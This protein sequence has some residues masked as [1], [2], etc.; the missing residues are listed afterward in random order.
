MLL[1]R[2]LSAAG[3][4]VVVRNRRDSRFQLAEPLPQL[5]RHLIAEDHG[6]LALCPCVLQR[7]A[8]VRRYVRLY[9]ADGS[10]RLVEDAVAALAQ[11][12]RLGLE[13]SDAHQQLLLL[14]MMIINRRLHTDRCDGRREQNLHFVCHNGVVKFLSTWSD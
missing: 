14:I 13:G 7:P 8:V 1:T 11:G 4:S 3:R 2:V 12:L 6:L 9:F 5:R 10:L